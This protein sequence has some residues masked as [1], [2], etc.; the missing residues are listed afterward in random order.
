MAMPAN[1]T[2]AVNAY[3]NA[4]KMVG[5][6]GPGTD[7]SGGSSFSD[8]LRSAAGSVQDTLAK[9][10]QASMQAVTGK[11]DLAQVTEAVSNAEVAVQTVVALRDRVIQAYQDIMRMPI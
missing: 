11:A 2:D 7:S 4:G 9:S 5:V 1:I 3:A 6:P 10:E 8:M